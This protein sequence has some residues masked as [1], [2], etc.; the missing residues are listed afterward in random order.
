MGERINRMA[1]SVKSVMDDYAEFEDAAR[2]TFGQQD[3][4]RWGPR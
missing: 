1:D 2:R 4:G 3:A